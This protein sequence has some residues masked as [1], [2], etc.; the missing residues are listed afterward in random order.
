[1]ATTDMLAGIRILDLTTVMLG[2]Y[3]TETLANMGADVIKLEPELGDE[4]RRV[5]KPAMNRRMGPVHLT[6]NRGKRSVVWDLKTA[7]GRR[8]VMDL[9]TSSDVLIHNLRQD[10][11][12][13]A[14][15]D[16]ESVRKVRP[17]IVYV[18]CTGFGSDGPYAGR[19]AYDDIIQAVSGATSLIP[20]VTGDETPRFLPL[21]IA[22]KVSGLHAVYAVLGALLYRERSGAGQAVEVPMLES[23]THF[24]LQE[25]MYAHTFVPP[26]GP[27]GY[28]RQLDPDR[29]PMATSDGHI[30]VAPYTDTRWLR[31]F[32]VV[33]HRE[34]LAVP[35]L[36]TP[37][38]RLK[39]VAI[40]QRAL[41]AIVAGR[42]SDHW[43]G[44]FTEHDIPCCRVNGLEQVFEDPH[45][46]ATG[47]FE[48]LT[49]PTEGDYIGLKPPVRFG[50]GRPIAVPHAPLIGEHTDSVRDSLRR[51]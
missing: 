37:I 48:R 35:E 21:A 50:A 33:G 3:C 23:F 46:V 5:G 13:R 43:L 49:H 27:A 19:P 32:D 15:L 18:H 44:L 20:R 45:L 6:M 12:E 24:L 8:D 39:N 14:G 22:D 9:I 2:P 1:M 16:Y 47:F 41:A 40:M 42:P 51:P 31:L 34:A 28:P 11:V 29:Q 30:V 17:D 26:N 25:H 4:I 38:L 10:A 36:E 7:E